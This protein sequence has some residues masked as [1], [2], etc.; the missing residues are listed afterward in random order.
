MSWSVLVSL[1]SYIPHHHSA[2]HRDLPLLRQQIVLPAVLGG[3]RAVDRGL[4]RL[5]GYESNPP[6]GVEEWL[7]SRRR[8][9]KP[10]KT[11]S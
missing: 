9:L 10:E 1:P 7:D 3:E 6:R 4:P 5:L 11:A 2:F 8:W